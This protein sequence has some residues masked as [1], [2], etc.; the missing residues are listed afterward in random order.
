[1]AG[2]L[3]KPQPISIRHALFQ[4][5]DDI[6]ILM[7]SV[8][9]KSSQS[10]FAEGFGGRRIPNWAHAS[11]EG[12]FC[13]SCPEKYRDLLPHI[14]RSL[15]RIH[16]WQYS[17]DKMGI[18]IL[19]YPVYYGVCMR[20]IRHLDQRLLT[21]AVRLKEAMILLGARQVGKTTILKRLF[22]AA[23]YLSVDNEQTRATLERYDIS[24]YRELLP[25][26]ASSVIIDEIHL[27]KDPGR[28]AKILYDQMPKVRL[29][30]TGSSSLSIKNRTTESLAG[31]K[32]DY[33]LFPL[34]IA[35]YLAQAG[36][37]RDLFYPVLRHGDSGP[38]FPAERVYPYDVAAVTDFAATWG[39]YP[40][41]MNHADKKAY[42]TNLVDSVVF[43]DLLEL[44]LIEHRAAARSLLK[45]LAYQIGNLVNVNELAMRLSIDAKT[46]RRYLTLFE[47]SFI[48][49]PLYP[50]SRGKRKEIGKMPKIYFFDCGLR[51]ALIGS[52]DSMSLRA[53]AG[54]LFENLVISEM[55][56]AN[57]YGDFGYSMNFWRTTDGSE[58]DVVLEKGDS[59]IGMEIKLRARRP[60]RA[61]L[62]RY[63]R[64]R[65]VTLTPKNYL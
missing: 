52:F 20:Y 59:T 43:R 32:I 46:V 29:F 64:A 36:T 58:I 17:P 8:A 30:L 50:Y 10:A 13:G 62:T 53:D 5:P 63:P 31:R 44:S 37:V 34:T 40:A 57:Y 19:K 33:H 14:V 51:N 42:L 15:R 16:L 25:Q 60:N 23:H 3:K 11:E 38:D 21:H 41:V 49:F 45:L 26:T 28:A 55:Y 18:D 7:L 4:S 6:G 65:L 24:A 1:M 22:P 35:E 39:L 47:Q 54:V 56:K 12:F 2:W 9:G 61:F 48:I 27:L